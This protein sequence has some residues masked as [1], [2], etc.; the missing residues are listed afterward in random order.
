SDRA[1]CRIRC[2]GGC[3][4]GYPGALGAHIGYR[5]ASIVAE[6]RV[7]LSVP[8]ARCCLL[9]DVVWAGARRGRTRHIELLALRPEGRV[10]QRQV[11]R[12]AWRP[13][14]RFVPTLLGRRRLRAAW[15]VLVC[16]SR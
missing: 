4:C 3:R 9:A 16:M 13:A 6:A 10:L 8:S 7:L 11:T 12:T 2:R 14:D 15:G 5:A 1:V